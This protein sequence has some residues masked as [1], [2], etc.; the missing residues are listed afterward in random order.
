VL[1]DAIGVVLAVFLEHPFLT[2]LVLL[3]L[4]V[5][6]YIFSTL[7]M[8]LLLAKSDASKSVARRSV[9]AIIPVLN[10]ADELAINIKSL[11]N[12]SQKLHEIII[13]DDGS[14]DLDR[15]KIA[16]LASQHDNIRLIQHRQ[17]AGKSASVNH[18]AYMATGQL[19]LVVD[20]DTWLH[21]NAVENLSQAFNDPSVGMASGNL[22]VSN[23][24]RN[25]ITSIQSLEYMLSITIGRGFLNYISAMSCC[26]GA[27]TMF[28]ANAFRTLGGLNVGPGEDLEIT[29]RFR[30]VGYKI[31]FVKQALAETNVP[32]TFMAL[33]RQ[34]LRWDGDALAIRLL[35]YRELRFFRG[36]ESTGD[37][38]QRLDY[39]FLELLPTLFFPIYLVTLWVNYHHNM[40]DIL[41]AIY[42]LLFWIYVLN[43]CVAIIATKRRLSVL[44]I[45]VIPVLPIYQGFVMRLVR[46][47]A[48]TDE[49]LF[50]KSHDSNFVP[51]RI[52]RALYETKD[53]RS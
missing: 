40:V 17:R 5:P 36:R 28:N 46:L 4:E 32:Q 33:I 24:Q 2:I 38:L 44:D 21:P 29:L 22:L 25:P 13:V 37:V 31:R 7:F 26:S 1:I 11:V 8:G 35:M 39:I 15:E 16:A 30:E 41:A 50:A 42:I 19:L 52:R 10:G 43:I 18:A 53:H 45:L 34:R 27:F 49:I 47:V 23:R 48:I 51:Y 14:G 3:A 12:Q 6:R 20:H 9:S